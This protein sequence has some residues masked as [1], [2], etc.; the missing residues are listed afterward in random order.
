VGG[1]RYAADLYAQQDSIPI[2][3]KPKPL[4]SFQE[5]S[6]V[7][8][9]SKKSPSG[10]IWKKPTCTKQKAGQPAGHMRNNK[11]WYVSFNRQQLLIH[12]IIYF[13]YYQSDISNIT[14]DHID[15]NTLNNSIE[16]LR[17]S[18]HQEQQCNKKGKQNLSSKYKGVS[19]NKPLQKWRVSICINKKRMHIGYY[20]N[21]L[22]AAKA[23]NQVA[24]KLH[25]TFA[26]LN[27]V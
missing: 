27:N 16:N 20:T 22:E 15:Q 8:E 17:R 24:E 25:G 2:H 11:Y 9:I 10:L 21:E 6:N 5:L 19:W 18:T 12:R 4:P 3:M 1:G 23:Y 7:F 26:F 14:I 13:L